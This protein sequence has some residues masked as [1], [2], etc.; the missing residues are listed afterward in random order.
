MFQGILAFNA[1]T[2]RFI[3]QLE[4]EFVQNFYQILVIARLIWKG[5]FTNIL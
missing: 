1:K 3:W 2:L 4:F 5:T